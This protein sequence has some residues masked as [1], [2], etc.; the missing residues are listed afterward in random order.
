MELDLSNGM[1]TP[2]FTKFQTFLHLSQLA[3]VGFRLPTGKNIIDSAALERAGRQSGAGCSGFMQTPLLSEWRLPKVQRGSAVRFG[4]RA[5][6]GD[7]GNEWSVLVVCVDTHVNPF[8]ILRMCICMRVHV[9][10]C[11]VG[12]DQLNKSTLERGAQSSSPTH[13]P[14]VSASLTS[15]MLHCSQFIMS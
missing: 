8:F 12:L 5:L 2:D 4:L 14:S 13:L 7:S 9:C 6:T 1:F 10:V 15:T 3:N 11:A